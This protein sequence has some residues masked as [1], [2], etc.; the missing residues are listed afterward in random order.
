MAGAVVIETNQNLQV[1]VDNKLMK[2]ATPSNYKQ[3]QQQ[4]QYRD[5]ECNGYNKMAI[6]LERYNTSASLSGGSL[7]SPSTGTAAIGVTSNKY[8]RENNKNEHNRPK[9]FVYNANK[10]STSSSSPVTVPL[11]L[12]GDVQLRFLCPE[13]LE[14]V[15]ALCQDWFP[16]D[17]PYSWYED[18]TSSSRFYALAAVFGGVIIGL[19]VA[20]I[21]PFATLNKEDQGILCSSLGKESLVGYILSLGVRRAYRRNGIASLLL[22]QLL[23]HV[24][25]PERSIVKAVFLHVLSSNAPA[26]LFYQRCNFRLHSFLPYYYSIRGKCR[27]GFTYVLY[28]NGGHAPWGF[29]DWMRH[30]AGAMSSLGPCRVPH[31]IWQR[32]MWA[33]TLLSYHR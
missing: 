30:L 1:F 2:N 20:E 9:N 6:S 11:C 31:W 29:W 28:V 32:L 14:E 3:Q 16:I 10:S 23:A 8:N 19:I 12:L 7:S 25:A 5:R 18:I 27:D 17:Y 15:R 33:A 21:K 4:Q 13:D 26:I 24:T 22:E